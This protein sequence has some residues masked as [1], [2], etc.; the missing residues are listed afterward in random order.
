[1]AISRSLEE[2]FPC[3]PTSSF[4]AVLKGPYTGKI[5]R[6]SE[7]C[8]DSLKIK[9]KFQGS[10]LTKRLQRYHS[11]VWE[12]LCPSTQ[13]GPLSVHCTYVHCGACT[14]AVHSCW[15][16]YVCW[17]SLVK[18]KMHLW[19][20]KSVHM[21]SDGSRMKSEALQCGPYYS[22]VQKLSPNTAVPP[23]PYRVSGKWR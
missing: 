19:E 16:L 8:D 4:L 11:S 7:R 13:Y 9:H 5:R 2:T 20:N 14:A 18:K 23:R 1:M 3:D 6:S 12:E 17:Y 15:V 10:R 22:L 21:A